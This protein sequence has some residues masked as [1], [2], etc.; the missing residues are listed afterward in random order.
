MTKFYTLI[1][2]ATVVLYSCKTATKAFEKGNYEDA[3]SLAVKKLQKDGSD[4]ASKAI[5]KDAYRQAVNAHEAII[6]SLTNSNS[7]GSYE[8]I[9]NEYRKLQNLYDA[10]NSS[11]VAMQAV[12]ATDYSAYVQTYK[13]KTGEVYFNRGLA[14]MNNGDRNS[15]RQAY[16]ALRTAYRYKNDTEIK[17]KM[18]E[19]HDAAVIKVLL[20]TDDNYS[21][22]NNYGGGYYGTGSYGNN[23]YNN[24]NGVYGN[25]S[26]EIRN[27]HE[28]LLRNLRYQ[29]NSEFVEFYDEFAARSNNIQPDEIVEMHLGRIDMGRSYDETNYRDVSNRIVVKQTVYKPDSI[30]NEYATVY[31]RINTTK[32]IYVSGGELQIVARDVHGKYLWNDVV[33]GEHRFATEFATYTGDERALSSSDK[34]LINNSNSNGYNQVRQQDIYKE[35]L[36]QIESEAGNRFRTYYSRYN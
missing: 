36:R 28:E 14:L 16:E 32:R 23:S 17:L 30:V 31:A 11:P 9:Y 33:R 7:D 21:N 27:F 24:G 3:V 22:G 6:S 1:L 2:A 13:E 8:K 29:V 34:A 19:A 10:V 15:F 25:N 4:E 5:L 18:D 35:V 12:H 20:L 26:Y